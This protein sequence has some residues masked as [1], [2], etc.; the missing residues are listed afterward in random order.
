MKSNCFKMSTCVTTL[1][2]TLIISCTSG[3]NGNK[4]SDS[5][6]SSPTISDSFP[7]VINPGVGDTSAVIKTPPVNDDI[8]IIPDSAIKHHD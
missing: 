6:Y 4:L 3:E 7:S 8:N 1:V 5:T 2:I